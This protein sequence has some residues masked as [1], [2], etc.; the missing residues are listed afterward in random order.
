[1]SEKNNHDLDLEKFTNDKPKSIPDGCSVFA[2]HVITGLSTLTIRQKLRDELYIEE[3]RQKEDTPGYHVDFNRNCNLGCFQKDHYHVSLL[4]SF[5]ENRNKNKY[6]CET[7][8][9]TDYIEKLHKKKNGGVFLVTG[10]L[11]WNFRSYKVKYK[12]GKPKTQRNIQSVTYLA[13]VFKEKDFG[14]L[15]KIEGEHDDEYLHCFV[16]KDGMVHCSNLIGVDEKSFS[17]PADLLLPMKKDRD[18]L[19]KMNTSKPMAYLRTFRR[20]YEVISHGKEDDSESDSDLDSDDDSEPDSDDGEVGHRYVFNVEGNVFNVGIIDLPDGFSESKYAITYSNIF[21]NGYR[22]SS[23]KSAP[24]SI[25]GSTAFPTGWS[26]MIDGVFVPRLNRFTRKGSKGWEMLQETSLVD[27]A[28]SAE[29]EVF[30]Y[31]RDNDKETLSKVLLFQYLVP[32]YLRICGTIFNSVALV[33]DLSDNYNHRHRDRMDMCSIFITLGKGIN[34]GSTLYWGSKENGK[35]LHEENF[36]HGKFQVGPFDKVD[37]AGSHWTGP[38]GVLSF[39]ISKQVY[40][41]F[42]V[43]DNKFIDKL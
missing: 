20:V 21:K 23:C 39:Y 14:A 16:V 31:L 25:L 27:V 42:M 1:M 3:E 34:G 11:N 41:H 24:M 2:G 6:S 7:V 33:G 18:G 30:K 37:H 29:K 13:D 9:G 17:A 8:H 43:H 5:L 10:K 36:C 32:E 4:V 35:V 22:P 38:R 28:K 40:N 19:C 12:Q 26:Y 15:Q